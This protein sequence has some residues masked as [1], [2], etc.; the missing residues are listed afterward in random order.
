MSLKS[1]LKKPAGKITGQESVSKAKDIM[2]SRSGLSIL[3]SISFFESA[4]PLPILTDPFLVAAVLLDRLRVLRLILITTVTSVLGGVCAYFAAVWFLTD[5]LN[6]V[7]PELVHEFQKISEQNGAGTFII[8]LIGAVTPV[9]YTVVAWTVAVT[10]GSLWA[11]IGA[12][13]LGRGFRYCVVGYTTYRFGPAAVSYARKY[14]G[15][16]SI[17]LVL[18]AIAYWWIKM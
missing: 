9:P 12:S 17:L 4:F 13:F 15:L 14:I 6:M 7:S 18:L 10:E 2:Q 16:A 1:I 5:L 8:T 3:G 11:F